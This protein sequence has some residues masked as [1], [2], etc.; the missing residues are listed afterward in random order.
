MKTKVTLTID[1]ELVPRAKTYAAARGVSLSAIVEESLRARLSPEPA[2]VVDAW[3]GRFHLRDHAADPRFRR[4]FDKYIAGSERGGGR[5]S[6][7]E[8]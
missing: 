6:S 3:A 7:G 5:P 2:S 1:A 8:R 4:L